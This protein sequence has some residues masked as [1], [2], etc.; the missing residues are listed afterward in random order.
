MEYKFEGHSL[1]SGVYRLTNKNNGKV[2]IGSAKRFKERWSQHTA[3]LRICRLHD[4]QAT[5]LC[6]VL[7]GRRKTTK[8][9]KLA[10]IA[11]EILI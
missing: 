10:T 11:S 4:L 9:W 7:K 3:S 1:K 5:K 2:Y 6:A 8:G